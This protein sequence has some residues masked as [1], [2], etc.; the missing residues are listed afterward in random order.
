M[1]PNQTNP[2]S[3]QRRRAV[4]EAAFTGPSP[5]WRQRIE[6]HRRRPEDISDLDASC[7]VSRQ[8][9]PEGRRSHLVSHLT[10]DKEAET[11]N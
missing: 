9:L 11:E 3:L 7:R 6:P 10:P 1:R 5:A 2:F 8:L 4:A